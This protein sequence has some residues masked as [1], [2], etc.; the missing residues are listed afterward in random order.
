M[1]L[2]FIALRRK[3]WNPQFE[4]RVTISTKVLICC[5]VKTESVVVSYFLSYQRAQ[6]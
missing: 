3:F 4:M 6:S 5:A 1:S 2:V